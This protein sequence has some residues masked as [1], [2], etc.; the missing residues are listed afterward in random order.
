MGC[1]YQHLICIYFTLYGLLYC[2]RL[3]VNG[4]YLHL[5]LRY[6]LC[7]VQ[8]VC[9]VV[10]VFQKIIA[11]TSFTYTLALKL[12]YYYL[13]ILDPSHRDDSIPWSLSLFPAD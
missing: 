12:L 6:D 1:I 3:I 2:S 11:Q 7:L 13:V 4:L 5:G 10:I 9:V 8:I